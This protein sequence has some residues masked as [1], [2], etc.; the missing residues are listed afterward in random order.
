MLSKYYHSNQNMTQVESKVDINVISALLDDLMKEYHEVGMSQISPGGTL[1]VFFEVIL[2]KKRKFVKT[3][4][5]GIKYQNNLIKEIDVMSHIYKN[6][7]EIVR[8]DVVINRMAYTFMIMDYLQPADGVT[9]LDEVR[10]YISTYQQQLSEA[11]VSAN[12]S[13]DEILK[14]ASDSLEL[15]FADAF[16]SK[17]IYMQ[18]KNS[19]E[20]VGDKANRL[21]PVICHGDLSNVNI[22][23]TLDG[24]PVV[25]DWEDLLTAF[26]EYDFLYW[27]TFFSQRKYYSD[28][29]F[30]K[31]N[32]DKIWGTD[33]M[34]LITII[35]SRLS[36]ENESYKKN[37]LSFQD[38]IIE[39]YNIVN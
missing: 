21:K 25:I 36:Y 35:K 4:L 10:M 9:G 32:I 27:L 31:Y 13:F 15:L 16:F 38:R 7:L 28:N 14:A 39:I 2:G 3:H 33:V 6:T 19:I 30:E 12:Y 26:P 20:R 29:I 23:R 24:N 37:S 1:G 17:Y 5:P 34:V 11:K 22:M 18:C 8:K